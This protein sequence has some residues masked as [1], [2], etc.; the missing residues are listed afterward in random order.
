[1]NKR[2]FSNDELGMMSPK[3]FRSIVRHGEFIGDTAACCRGYTPANLVIVPKDVA[4][5]FSLFC[6]HNPKPCP[7]LDI[8]E[9]GDP[10]PKLAAPD[11]DLR[12]DLPRYRVYK[13]G[14]LVDEPNDIS[15]Y[16]RDDLVA[17]LMGSSYGFDWAL[18]DA[19][20]KYRF[21]GAFTTNIECAP[22]GCF[23]GHMLVSAR[24][25]KGS[26]N[27]VRATQ[28]SSRHIASHGAPI[29]IGD[30][31]AI[32]IKDLYHPDIYCLPEV[33]AH[34][35]PDEIAMYWGCGITP[36]VAA[37]ESKV[38]FMITHWPGHLFVTDWLAEE[39]AIL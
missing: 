11:A 29:H 3:E 26:H 5:D 9:P 38:P 14:K 7:V 24:F 1:M 13:N 20:V 32:G 25:I 39:L 22:G 8:T 2:I 28:I 27:A 33:I 36:Q 12:T 23:H 16:W 37:M 35:E 6:Q 30:P 34:Q 21:I 17:F 10:C 4:F 19:N 18:Q 31:A 15:S